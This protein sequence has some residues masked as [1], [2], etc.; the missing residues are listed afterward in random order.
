MKIE[1]LY[2]PRV[3]SC[4]PSDPLAHAA[5]LLT[6]AAVGAL[7]VLREDGTL[8]GILSEQDIVRALSQRRDAGTATVQAYASLTVAVAEPDDDS[9]VIG[10]R[11]LDAGIWHLPVIADGR[12]AGMV[13]MRDVLA[14]QTWA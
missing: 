3:L 6:R 5:Q 10:G 4:S 11:M 1:Y 13:S 9:W 14:V 12:L 8:V 2:T 7:P